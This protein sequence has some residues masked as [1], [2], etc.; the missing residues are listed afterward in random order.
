[1]DL[2]NRMSLLYCNLFFSYYNAFFLFARE[3][4]VPKFIF[5]IGGTGTGKTTVSEEIKLIAEAQ[6]LTVTVLNLDHYY[7]P[8]SMLEPGKPK[9]YDVPEALE[10]SL[11][12]KHLQNLEAGKS[13]ARPTYDIRISDRVESGE[14]PVDPADVI[15]VEGIFAGEYSSS[16]RKQTEKLKIYLQSN[17]INDNYTRKEE[18]DM[19]E[20]KR[21]STH[22][23]AVKRNQMGGFFRYVATHMISSDI[24]IDNP[25]LPLKN[26]PGTG[27]IP[28]IVDSKLT[29]LNG[30]LSST[31]CDFLY[32]I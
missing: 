10:Q 17:Q 32:K 1:M 4:N 16:L 5:V 29:K 7:L 13:I 25:W 14:V 11:I 19:V 27:K 2:M 24:V 30:F 15:I 12:Q 3:D 21:S 22:I 6:Q 31:E 26:N 28:L 18:R 23:N 20:R 9:N 8:K